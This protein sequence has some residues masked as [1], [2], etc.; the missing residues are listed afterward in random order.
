MI[1][2]FYKNLSEKNK[3][4]FDTLIIKLI[5]WKLIP[6]NFLPIGYRKY[7]SGESLFN[8]QRKIVEDNRGFY[9]V[10][11][12]FSEDQLDKYYKNT[13]WGEF[14]NDVEIYISERDITHYNLILK[15]YADFFSKEKIIIVNF[16]SGHGGISFLFYFQGHTVINIDPDINVKNNLELD[17][18]LWKTLDSITKL[19]EPFDLFY[20]SHSLE[21]V[22][23]IDV[24]YDRLNTKIIDD[25]RTILFF[26]VPDGEHPLNGGKSGKILTPHTY[27][28]TEYFFKSLPFEIKLLEKNDRALR[29][30]GEKAS[31]KNN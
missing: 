28:F 9:Y 17:K 21:H 13:Y 3:K 20:S 14:R 15:Y 16:G 4:K 2:I 8:F 30:I 26:E 22:H 27:Y 12:K 5:K 11:P 31:L 6:K 7:I 19:K 23:D 1:K 25:K 29:Y 18:E 24:F 10:F